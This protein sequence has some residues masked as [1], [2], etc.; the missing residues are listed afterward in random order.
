MSLIIR[1]VH[2]QHKI[3][4]IQLWGTKVVQNILQRQ[5]QQNNTRKPMNMINRKPKDI[6]LTS[7]RT[8][9]R[10][11]LQI[12]EKTCNSCQ[13][14]FLKIRLMTYWVNVLL[15]NLSKK[16]KKTLEPHLS[17]MCNLYITI[18]K[19]AVC[20]FISNQIKQMT[21]NRHGFPLGSVQSSILP[22]DGY[23]R[24]CCLKTNPAESL[25]VILEFVPPL[26]MLYPLVHAAAELYIGK[27][28]D[29]KHT[30]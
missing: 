21:W 1:E 14:S 18:W 30:G 8:W 15:Y 24:K 10:F 7:S 28:P 25:T 20:F 16:K 2:V 17:N 23:Y 4:F 13:D 9:S 19:R 27:N 26:N 12:H 3:V 22:P 11:N 5:Q 29:I 6:Q